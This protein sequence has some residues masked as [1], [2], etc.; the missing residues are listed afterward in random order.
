MIVSWDDPSIIYC[1]VYCTMEL[2]TKHTMLDITGVFLFFIISD[3]HVSFLLIEGHHQ[4]FKTSSNSFVKSKN[5]WCA[6][7]VP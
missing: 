7:Q 2:A 3:H 1:T 6:N 5:V 4:H